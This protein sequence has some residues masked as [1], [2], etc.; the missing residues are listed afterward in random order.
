M[1]GQYGLLQ[2][3]SP[4]SGLWT[5][6]GPRAKLWAPVIYVFHFA[7]TRMRW[8]RTVPGTVTINMSTGGQCSL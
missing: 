3:V 4:T 5:C 1:N 2:Q 7:P 8:K 6:P